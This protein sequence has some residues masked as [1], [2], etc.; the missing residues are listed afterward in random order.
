VF[1]T[2]VHVTRSL[3]GPSTAVGTTL[4]LGVIAV[5]VARTDVG[6]DG[7]DAGGAGLGRAGAR[8]DDVDLVEEV[9]AFTAR[10]HLR[11]ADLSTESIPAAL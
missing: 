2:V 6:A 9:T 8:A 7:R 3:A 11:H 4:E 10:R 1:R 5:C